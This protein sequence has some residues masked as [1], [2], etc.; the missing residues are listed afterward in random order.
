M[1]GVAVALVV[2]GLVL[3][4]IA[5]PFGFAV[6]AVGLVL[7]VIYLTGFGRRASSGRP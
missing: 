6:G 4:F 1:I 3:G 2:I 7:F 5:G